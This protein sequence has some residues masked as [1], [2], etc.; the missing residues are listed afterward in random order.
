L[1]WQELANSTDCFCEKISLSLEKIAQLAE[2][3]SFFLKL[4]HEPVLISDSFRLNLSESLDEIFCDLELLAEG[5]KI[6]F[7]NYCSKNIFVMSAKKGI[8]KALRNLIF[9]AFIYNHSGGVVEV[10]SS[11][12]KGT[13]RL[14]ILDTGKGIAQKDLSFIFD[15]FYR[16][17]L[18]KEIYPE[19]SG[20]GLPIAKKIIEKHN[21]TLA[22]E[23]EEGNGSIFVITLPASSN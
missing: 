17:P 11:L 16:S 1:V 9:N 15:L 5:K 20:L 6:I 12:N 19:G 13:V 3:F 8:E 22:A 14:V 4:N 7:K 23:S 2:D 18:A 10:C 21:G